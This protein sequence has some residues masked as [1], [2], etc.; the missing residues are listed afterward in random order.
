MDL[1]YKFPEGLD[2]TLKSVRELTRGKPVLVFGTGM[3][4]ATQRNVSS[5]RNSLNL[6]MFYGK[7]MRIRVQKMPHLFASNSS[8]GIRRVRPDLHDVTK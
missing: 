3:A 6:P 8:M 1:H 2:W 7:L 4:I 5:S